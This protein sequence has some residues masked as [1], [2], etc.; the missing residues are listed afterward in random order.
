MWRKKLN[1][2]VQKNSMIKNV[3]PVV[4]Y[5]NLVTG[6]NNPAITKRML[7][8]QYVT[9]KKPHLVKSA[10]IQYIINLNL[11]IEKYSL[12]NKINISGAR[13]DQQTTNFI[14]GKITAENY[15]RT[16][17]SLFTD[18]LSFDYLPKLLD[19]MYPLMPIDK[20]FYLKSYADLIIPFGNIY[21]QVQT[22]NPIATNINFLYQY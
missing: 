8:S 4:E 13:L 6:G 10:P 7:Y 16:L 19:G 14:A 11:F 9:S 22:Q 17:R 20:R 1:C 18:R 3:C 15:F 5:S 12:E 2:D 21:P